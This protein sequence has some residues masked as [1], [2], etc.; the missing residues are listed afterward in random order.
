MHLMKSI[1][2]RE[3][4]AKEL[5]TLQIQYE[6]SEGNESAI[7]ELQKKL[8]IVDNSIYLLSQ[9]KQPAIAIDTT[10]WK[11]FDDQ[12]DN[13]TEFLVNFKAKLRAMDVPIEK[14]SIILFSLCNANTTQKLEAKA[15]ATWDEMEQ[16]F[17]ESFANK[18]TIIEDAMRLFQTA[19]YHTGMKKWLQEV[20]V[21]HKKWITRTDAYEVKA[22]ALLNELFIQNLPANLQDKVRTWQIQSGTAKWSATQV[23]VTQLVNTYRPPAFETKPISESKGS[24]NEPKVYGK[25]DFK[26][27]RCDMDENE[28]E[29]DILLPITIDGYEL[30]G[31]LDTGA[32]RS[33][34]PLRIVEELQLEQVRTDGVL[35]SVGGLTERYGTTTKLQVEFNGRQLETVFEI[36]PEDDEILIG[37]DLFRH[38]GLGINGIFTKKLQNDHIEQNESPE[39]NVDEIN[40]EFIGNEKLKKEIDFNK[41]IS[42][43]SVCS[44]KAAIIS[45]PTT[46]KE[47]CY[48]PQYPIKP[49]FKKTVDETVEEWLKYGRISIAP[50]PGSPYNNALWAVPKKDESGTKTGVRV[51]NDM[52]KLNKIL[53]DDYF[54]IPSIDTLLK[55]LEGSKY[56]SSLDLKDSYH[57]FPLDPEDKLKTAFTW[58]GNQY[59]FNVCP[60]GLKNMTSAFQRVMTQL[61]RQCLKFTIVYIDDIVIFS[62]TKEEH[63]QH[64]E[65][66]ME[67]INKANLRLNFTKCK[68]HQAEMDILGYRISS[69]GQQIQDKKVDAI[70][71]WELPENGHGIQRFLGFANYS[72]KFIPNFAALTA[73]LVKLQNEKTLTEKM[74]NDEAKNSFSQLKNIIAK[75]IMLHFPVDEI[76]LEVETDASNFGIGAVLL[77]TI[78]GERKIVNCASRSLKG[79]EKNYSA[80]KRELLAIV[81]ALEA[82]R[83]YLYGKKFVLFT[84]HQPLTYIWTK[85]N[86]SVVLTTWMDII[87]EYDFTITYKPGPTNILADALSRQQVKVYRT[88]ISASDE[89]NPTEPVKTELDIQPRI[90]NKYSKQEKDELLARAHGIA[91]VNFSKM[92]EWL[93]KQGTTWTGIY[94]DAKIFCRNCIPC[95]EVNHY[96][97]AFHPLSQITSTHP[98]QN[99]QIDLITSLPNSKGNTSILTVVDVFTKMTFIMAIQ[100]KSAEEVVEKLADLFLRMGFPTILQS[101]NGREFDNKMI[102]LLIEKFNVKHQL[103]APYYPQANG[104]V[105]RTNGFIKQVLK[106]L[107]KKGTDWAPLL[108]YVE[109]GI[110][111]CIHN[112]HKNIPFELFFNRSAIPKKN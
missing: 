4:L 10:N 62:K 51:C 73:P 61:L 40:C 92:I 9:P 105:E 11:Q 86:L 1:P 110:N 112:I 55:R 59:V 7:L 28:Y 90:G 54:P 64:L 83:E 60:F 36:T 21:I 41:S 16:F 94:R 2:K 42:P 13:P 29:A 111:N 19:Q 48:T 46:T 47:I 89:K 39:S 27:K 25:R 102:R 15:N 17:I 71:S 99:V 20:E 91:H 80:T 5:S 101:D 23:I 38:G 49:Q 77:Q 104:I 95:I 52:R 76:L 70:L 78:D 33:C 12:V 107:C 22:E 45:L 18:T 43:Y 103:T 85:K 106:K 58:N 74:W 84:D 63:D 37:L 67:C 68:F 32:T 26:T 108:P 72:R 88:T 57:Q 69:K 50:E 82:F 109:H 53:T 81:F 30:K 100:K 96:P 34:I 35:K 56:F 6:G 97:H 87:Q 3:R 66:V 98:F 79:S 8:S 14:Y 31:V 65:K 24:S 93:N 44:L 75:K